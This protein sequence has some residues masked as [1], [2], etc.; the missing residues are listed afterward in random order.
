MADNSNFNQIEN[1]GTKAN[2]FVN[3]IYSNRNMKIYAIPENELENLA[4]INTLASVFFSIFSFCLSI[5][6]AILL[7]AV[8]ADNLSSNLIG[9]ILLKYMS[10]FIFFYLLFFAPGNIFCISAATRS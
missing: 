1:I 5:T 3:P 7:S 8:Y 2:G 9:E 4:Y 10:P 6:L